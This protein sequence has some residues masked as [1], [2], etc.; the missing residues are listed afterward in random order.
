MD[1]HDFSGFVR[2]MGL[3]GIKD[4][5]MYQD[6][7]NSVEHFGDVFV[8]GNIMMLSFPDYFAG[9]RFLNDGMLNYV[10]ILLS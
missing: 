9:G 1:R 8:Y 4:F 3:D 10:F 5:L 2:V 6:I 7:F